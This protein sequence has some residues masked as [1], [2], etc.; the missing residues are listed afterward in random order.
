MIAISRTNLLKS[1]NAVQ[2]GFLWLT[3]ALLLAGCASGQPK[4]GLFTTATHAGTVTIL[5]VDDSWHP[6]PEKRGPYKYGDSQADYGRRFVPLRYKGDF[7]HLDWSKKVVT[8]Q[9]FIVIS[10]KSAF[11]KYFKERNIL[12]GSWS[13][14]RAKGE[15][16]IILSFS[17][18]TSVRESFLVYDSRGQTLGSFLNLDD[19]PIIGPVQIDGDNLTVRVVVLELDQV[20]NE[21]LRQFAQGLAG[22]ATTLQPSL[23]GAIK[24]ALPAA[25]LLIGLNMDDV[26][27]DQKFALKRV[28]LGMPATNNP[29]LC[30]TYVLVLQ[31]DRLRGHGAEVVASEAVLP[32]VA[33]RLRFDTYSHRLYRTYNYYPWLYTEKYEADTEG[34]A[35]PTYSEENEATFMGKLHE[36]KGPM[37]WSSFY[38]QDNENTSYDINLDDKKYAKCVLDEWVNSKHAINIRQTVLGYQH[39]KLGD[40]GIYP[41]LDW[42][43][44]AAFAE[45]VRYNALSIEKIGEKIK[46][47]FFYGFEAYKKSDGRFHFEYPVV[48]YPEAFTLLAQYPLHTHLVFSVTRSLAKNG[49]PV[50]DKFQAYKDYIEEEIKSVKSD[51][52]AEKLSQSLQKTIRTQKKQSAIFKK[53]AALDEATPK[54]VCLLTE[55]L[56]SDEAEESLAPAFID[57]PVFNEMYSD[58]NYLTVASSRG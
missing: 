53:V 11:I 23:G 22:L 45:G 12:S 42:A 9:D 48:S 4:T 33:D 29:L 3:V 16:A 38:A 40:L 21:Q 31:E 46:Q 28:S 10:L 32:P 39:D 57:A 13:P 20:E 15:I 34:E 6:N 19:W 27:L 44:K 30:G 35:C 50:H 37:E 41:S 8:D 36:G 43:L 17:A 49:E 25:E 14:S 55:V 56:S 58:G 2:L 54:K 7:R 18:G 5:R 1:R 47:V 52:R 24:L 51:D 26:I